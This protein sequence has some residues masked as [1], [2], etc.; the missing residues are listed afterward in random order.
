MKLKLLFTAIAMMLLLALPIGAADTNEPYADALAALGMFRGTENGY[1]LERTATRAEAITMLVRVLGAEEEALSE[2][3]EHPFTDT[4]Q[5]ADGYI[6]YAY[7]HGITRGISDTAFGS[8][9]LVDRN[10]YATLLLRALGYSDNVGGPFYYDSAYDFACHKFS[11]EPSEE[12]FDRGEMARMTYAALNTPYYNSSKTLAN[13]LITKRVFT[14]S[15]FSRAKASLQHGEMTTAV[16]IYAVA[17]DLESKLGMLSQDIGE[18]LNAQTSDVPI[19]MQTGGTKNYRNP[20]LHDKKTQRLFITDDA[21]TDITVLENANMCERQTLEDFLVYAREN[22]TADRYVLI[23]WDHGEGTLGGFGM[24]EL[25]GNASLSIA[26]VKTALAAFGQKFD[27]I[28]FDACLMGTAEC[29]YALS[30]TAEYLI[31]SEDT[32]PTEGIYYTTWMNALSLDP[33]L[34]TE[35]LARQIVDSYIVYAP[36]GR[37]DVTMSVIR[38]ANVP[39]LAEEIARMLD[40]LT[41]SGLTG[42]LSA[43]GLT[44]YGYGVGCDQYDMLTVFRA[45]DMDISSLAVALENTVY[46]RRAA[47]N[48]KYSGLAGYLPLIRRDDYPAAREILCAIGYPMG[49]IDAMDIICANAL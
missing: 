39:S 31:A 25:N 45:A 27:L 19:L 35:E 40:A 32:T 33:T 44:S 48:G 20:Q 24:D 17:S 11:M 9:M 21:L 22:I 46:Y 1:A 2:T 14:Q 23:F 4:A 16:L 26:D 49:A 3:R 29:A 13:D 18:I 6:G 15:A 38:E 41:D 7:E 10:Q 30:D 42:E 36:A 12:A 28:V 43:A 47:M 34:P 5:W 37:T 8:D